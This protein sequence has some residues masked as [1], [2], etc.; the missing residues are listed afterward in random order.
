MPA[1]DAAMSAIEAYEVEVFSLRERLQRAEAHIAKLE[2][3]NATLQCSEFDW[4]Q[5]AEKAEAE[6][7]RVIQLFRALSEKTN[8]GDRDNVTANAVEALC[9]VLDAA[10]EGEE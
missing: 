10:R 4:K 7:S 5:R 2:Y 8:A 1:Y 6:V 3:V 9:D